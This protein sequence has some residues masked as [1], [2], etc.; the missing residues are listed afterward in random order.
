MNTVPTAVHRV[1]AGHEIDASAAPVEPVGFLLATIVQLLPFH[2]SASVPWS[3][4]PTARQPALDGHV[5]ALS[6]LSAELAGSGLETIDHA[7]PSQCS[8]SVSARSS[9]CDVPTAKQSPALAQAAPASALSNASVTLGLGTIVQWAPSHRS[10]NVSVSDVVGSGTTKDE[11]T[12]KQ[13]VVLEHATPDSTF[14]AE[15]AGFGVD[16]SVQRLL[17]QRIAIV[18][19]TV[20]VVY[21]PTAMQNDGL[22]HFTAERLLD[23]APAGTGLS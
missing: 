17:L 9:V 22:A 12:A 14:T 19:V 2:R 7:A 20:D 11:P 13:L 16:M 6:S 4:D 23:C 3:D 10:T 1:T 15:L 5:T 8:V 18:L 21:C